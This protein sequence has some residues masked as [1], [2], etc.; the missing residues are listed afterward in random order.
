MLNTTLIIVWIGF[1]AR[2]TDECLSARLGK[3]IQH[4]YRIVCFIQ[5]IEIG[6]N[7]YQQY[8]QMHQHFP[9]GGFIDDAFLDNIEQLFH[10]NYPQQ[11]SPHD[12]QPFRITKDVT[13]RAIDLISCN[14]RQFIILFDSTNAPKFSS[15][16]RPIVVISPDQ[17]AVTNNDVSIG[18][19]QH[20]QNKRK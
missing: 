13:L 18:Q 12:A 20:K 6:F 15:I 7:I 2:I 5:T 10:L 8:L 4:A 17:Q 9:A 11:F 1:D 19:N 3:A 16:G 14:M